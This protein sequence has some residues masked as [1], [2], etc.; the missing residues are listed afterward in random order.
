MQ[1]SPTDKQLS[2]RHSYSS[3]GEKLKAAGLGLMFIP[4]VD[5]VLALNSLGDRAFQSQDR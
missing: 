2:V 3:L 1:F 5:L 4:Q